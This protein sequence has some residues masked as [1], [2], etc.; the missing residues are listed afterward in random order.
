MP[1]KLHPLWYSPII[2]IMF[3]ISAIYLGLVMVMV[4]SMTS[5]YLYKK[6][7]ET[8]ILMKLRKYALFMIIF[9]GAFRFLDIIIRGASPFLFEESWGTFLFWAEITI[10]LIIPLLIFI[11]PVLY[12]NINFL[13]I[14]AL[15]GVTGIVF[16]RLNVGG[17]THLNNLSNIG[18]FYLPSWTEISISAGVVALAMLIFFFFIENFKVWEERPVDPELAPEVKPKLNSF[19]VY[20][21]PTNV[22]NRTK[23]SFAFVLAFSLSFALISG[24]EINEI[25]IK[26]TP[27]TKARGGDTLLIDGNRNNY[28]VSFKHVFHQQKG[29]TCGECH[30]INKPGDKATGCYEC[31]SDMYDKADAFRHDWH[32]SKEGADIKCIKCHDANDSKGREFKNNPQLAMQKCVECHEDMIPPDS[33]IQKIKTYETLSYSDAMHTMCIN[34]HEDRLKTDADLKLRK[35]DLANCA[36]CHYKVEKFIRERKLFE[37]SDKNKWV[38]LP[39]KFSR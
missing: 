24:T 4:E 7:P 36:T 8:D 25:G 22:R 31:H 32:A 2:P 12:R 39:N 27:V 23:M 3:F 26:P 15:L 16:N 6:E 18:Q 33:K 20:L 14:A 30:H 35:S 29:V 11:I 19:H 34:C 10:S 13:Y 1:Y 9:Y 17:L 28:G 5:S 37:K 38:V 21:G